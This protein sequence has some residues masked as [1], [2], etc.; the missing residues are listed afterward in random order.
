MED[1]SDI[2]NKDYLDFYIY[3]PYNKIAEE[4]NN[5]SDFDFIKEDLRDLKE[6]FSRIDLQL[7]TLKD[8]I[9]YKGL[10]IDYERRIEATLSNIEGWLEWAEEILDKMSKRVYELSH[11]RN[12]NVI[13]WY[14]NKA[15]DITVNMLKY[16][17]AVRNSLR[18]GKD[19][20]A[21]LNKY[22]RIT[23]EE[24]RD[25]ENLVKEMLKHI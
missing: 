19:D 23:N 18:F 1:F 13:L 2:L 8:E 5:F 25:V 14:L 21:L 22:L 10:D 7:S 9:P 17:Y 24:I 12:S 15:H 11:I 4:V 20:S 3:L 16:T 6:I